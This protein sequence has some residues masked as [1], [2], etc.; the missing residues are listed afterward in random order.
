VEVRATTAREEPQQGQLAAGT[1]DAAPEAAD[2]AAGTGA[3]PPWA[4]TA[5]GRGS[6]ADDR[7][8]ASARRVRPGP[9]AAGRLPL[10]ERP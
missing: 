5:S 10:P 2:A 8:P 3:G 6:W 1:A 4:G 9:P 7:R